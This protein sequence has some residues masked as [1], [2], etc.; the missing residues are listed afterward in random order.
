MTLTPQINIF[1]N[2][3]LMIKPDIMGKGDKTTK[4]GKI[5]KGSYGKSRPKKK[6]KIV[7]EPP[8]KKGKK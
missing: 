6:A 3:Y 2:P 4:R 1:V 5:I 8:K 7:E